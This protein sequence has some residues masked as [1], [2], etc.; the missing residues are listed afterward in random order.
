MSSPNKTEQICTRCGKIMDK[1]DIIRPWFD[2]TKGKENCHPVTYYSEFLQE[3]DT[4]LCG[5]VIKVEDKNYVL[6]KIGEEEGEILFEKREVVV[7]LNKGGY[8]EIRN[9]DDFKTDDQFLIK[10]AFNLIV[11]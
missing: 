8:T 11:E 1:F 6:V 2:R 7:G 3:D 5:P 4:Y 9:K 10:G